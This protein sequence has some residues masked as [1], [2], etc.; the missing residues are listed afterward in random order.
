MFW[1]NYDSGRTRVSIKTAKQAGEFFHTSTC[2][3]NRHTFPKLKIFSRQNVS[4]LVIS[5]SFPGEFFLEVQPRAILA[6]HSRHAD[7]QK[8]VPVL[9]CMMYSVVCALF[10]CV[11][12]IISDVLHATCPIINHFCVFV[13]FVCGSGAKTETGHIFV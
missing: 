8:S 10:T 5:H 13:L 12:I 11:T 1:F 3:N 9:L 2:K 4:G 6:C 7:Y